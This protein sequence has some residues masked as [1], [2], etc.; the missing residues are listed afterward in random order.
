MRIALTVAIRMVAPV[1]RCPENYRPLGGHGTRNHDGR[2]PKS[3][4]LVG[5]VAYQP[6]KSHADAE[7]SNAVHHAEHREVEPVDA[8]IP[9][10]QDAAG[11]SRIRKQHSS[12]RDAAL[13]A[14]R[15]FVQRMHSA[16]RRIFSCWL[17]QRIFLYL[18]L[19]ITAAS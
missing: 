4:C 10:K 5:A 18:G 6:V 7:H 17:R 3:G 15:T 19:H 16:R 12:K 11:K 13:Q 2:L 8:T 1:H 9:E 14:A